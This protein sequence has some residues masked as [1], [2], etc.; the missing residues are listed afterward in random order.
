MRIVGPCFGLCRSIGI[1]LSRVFE[2]KGRRRL[3]LGV[4]LG[5]FVAVRGHDL[6]V[7]VSRVEGWGMAA[8]VVEDSG[9]R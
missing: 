9:R 1:G 5:G 8:K 7:A 2:V 6:G 3:D 4:W